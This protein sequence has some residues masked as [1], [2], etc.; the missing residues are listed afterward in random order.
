M[1]RASVAEES[2]DTMVSFKYFYFMVKLF[3]FAQKSI[4]IL[5]RD[6]FGTGIVEL[7]ASLNVAYI[8]A[9]LIF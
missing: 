6:H 3:L 4:C 9:S 7:C 8:S 2:I 5:D 1:R